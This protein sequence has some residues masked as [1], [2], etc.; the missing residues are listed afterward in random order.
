MFSLKGPAAP[1]QHLGLT[2]GKA[3]E[4]N[5]FLSLLNGR[6][7]ERPQELLEHSPPETEVRGP[8]LTKCG[9]GHQL[10]WTAHSDVTPLRQPAVGSC[11]EGSGG[12]V[13]PSVG[14]LGC[15]AFTETP[16]SLVQKGG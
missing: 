9:R 14:A 8:R 7:R 2:L 16:K 12:R 11:P 4:D 1:S 15:S 3:P 6:G 5:A 10:P 13:S